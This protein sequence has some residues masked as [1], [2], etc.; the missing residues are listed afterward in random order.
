MIAA[1][2]IAIDP[3]LV[4]PLLHVPRTPTP[5]IWVRHGEGLVGWGEA[6]RFEV[7]GAKRMRTAGDWWRA[8]CSEA[9]VVDPVR[10]PGSG[11]VAF[12][13][14]AFDDDSAEASM[15]IVPEVVVGRRGSVAWATAVAPL[16]EQGELAPRLRRLVTAL[17][18]SPP[19]CA[20]LGDGGAGPVLHAPGVR[21]E[22][23]S[24][25]E[26]PPSC[27]SLQGSRG[28]IP[29]ARR[30]PGVHS[31]RAW[32]GIV[33]EAIAAVGRGEVEKVVLARDE[34]VRA[35]TSIDLRIVAE[36]LARAYPSCWTY[37]VDGLVGA[38]PEMLVRSVH[39]L[40]TSRVLAG[41]IRR[42]DDDGDNLR[43]A[44]AL[45]QSSKDLAEHEFAVASV[46]ERLAEFA[47]EL[48]V[49]E[50]PFVL[51]LANVMHLATDVTGVARGG[52]SSLDVARAL[53]PTAAV[54]GTPTS[55]ARELLARLEAMDRGRYAGPVGWMGDDGDGEWA[56]ALRVAQLSSDRRE[57]R[58]FAG[59][60][61]V[62]G[63]I[64]EEELAETEAKLAPMRDALGVA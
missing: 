36:R 13:S 59:G 21:P 4:D 60:G 14:F 5:L 40:L 6:L 47:V 35:E 2:T 7:R 25:G 27:A 45:A 12:G 44:R 8:V 15:L 31:A 30:H 32:P 53:H 1:S 62:A 3:G 39:G 64:P 16:H 55:A 51:P 9:A 28:N 11:L 17:Q 56:I 57:A 50:A 33:G 34:V 19:S 43:R 61:I 37:C 49:P 63:S 20:G 23:G 10:A 41:T 46:A 26:P 42:T 58:L 18:D 54:C 24:A 38:T 29:A 52:P 22:G 48:N